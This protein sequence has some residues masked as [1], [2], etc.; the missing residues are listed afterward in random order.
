M[1]PAAIGSTEWSEIGKLLSNFW[2]VVLFVILFA[3]N[4]LLG[5]NFIPSLVASKDIPN[6]WQKARP[7]FYT[8]ALVCLSLAFFFLYRVIDYAGVLHKIWPDYWI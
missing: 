8:L 6:G 5:H 4:M 2:A 3:T 1:D 7:A